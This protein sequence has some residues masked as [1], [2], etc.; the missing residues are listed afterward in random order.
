MVEFVR[1]LSRKI[2]EVDANVPIEREELLYLGQ[3][4][5]SLIF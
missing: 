2:G 1:Y 5:G 3:I 4:R